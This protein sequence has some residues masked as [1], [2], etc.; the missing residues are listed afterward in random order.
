MQIPLLMP[1]LKFGG[2]GTCPACASGPRAPI[3][4]KLSASPPPA[5]APHQLQPMPVLPMHP[6]AVSPQATTAI[7]AIAMSKDSRPF[8]LT[9]CPASPA[10]GIAPAFSPVPQTTAVILHAATAA[11]SISSRPCNCCPSLLPALTVSSHHFVLSH[12]IS[13]RLLR[14]VPVSRC[15]SLRPCIFG[16]MTDLLNGYGAGTIM[17][18]TL[19]TICLRFL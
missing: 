9:A 15:P 8:S 4:V 2:M 16:C 17:H 19:I 6:C 12:E 7:R 14:T 1:L 5:P 13:H 3:P 11:W 10:L 18:A